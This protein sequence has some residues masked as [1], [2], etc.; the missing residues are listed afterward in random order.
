MASSKKTGA[1][2]FWDWLAENGAR[3]RAGLKRG[4][5][6]VARDVGKEF[7]RA[8]PGLVWEVSVGRGREP[9]VFCLSANGNRK[10][11]PRVQRAV[12]EAPKVKGWKIRAFRPRGP[13]DA[14]ISLN[15]QTLDGDDVWCE[16]TAVKG[17]VSV[18]LHL[19]GVTVQTEEVLSQMALIL[20]D[21]AIGEY[22]SVMK[23]ADVDIALLEGTPRASG[24]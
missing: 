8:Y 5:A 2:Q 22:D 4:V 16:V 23:I 21:N 20:M 11:F 7:K 13:V 15:G 1:R 18:V 17:G 3:V 14:E 9:W 24:N 6:E 12:E 19:R 10:L